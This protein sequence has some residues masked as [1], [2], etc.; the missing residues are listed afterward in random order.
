MDEAYNIA[1]TVELITPA[2]F[3]F[4]GGQTPKAWTEK[5]LED[6]H[7]KVLMYEPEAV[8]V[9]ANTEIKGG[10]AIT[11]RDANKNY[12]KIGIFTAYEEMNSILHK[13]MQ[14]EHTPIS[15]IVSSQGI[16]KF[17]EQAFKD[18]PE[19]AEVAGS[20]TG[21]KIISRTISLLPEVF[22]NEEDCTSKHMKILGRVSNTRCYKA[23]LKKY[24]QVN[25]YID[26]FNLI[27]PKASGNG[28]FGETMS[29]F[30][31]APPGVGTTDTFISVGTFKT[32]AEAK[33]VGI[34]FKTKFLRALLGT[35]K[36]N[37]DVS[38]EKF[39]YIPIQDFT[40]SSDIDW[41]ASIKNI[42]RQLYKKYGLSQEEID[43]IESHVKEME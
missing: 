8:K 40:P 43:F 14:S 15:T 27:V 4:G 25:P 31:V 20:G 18:H 41:S 5:M 30:E 29:G 17:S 39:K 21:A 37:Q 33:A 3:L 22:L 1:N 6:E 9:F 11:L 38:P 34:Y 16:Y 36:V 10:V 12:G 23:V 24:I 26:S 28:I 32:K 2:R 19:I 7:L 42:D 35:V 13:I